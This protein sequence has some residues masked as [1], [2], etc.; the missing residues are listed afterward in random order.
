MKTTIPLLILLVAF[1]SCE[2]EQNDFRRGFLNYGLQLEDELTGINVVVRDSMNILIDEFY[3]I[4]Y[5]Q[6]NTGAI[7]RG[8]EFSNLLNYS[9]EEE[10]AIYILANAVCEKSYLEYLSMELAFGAVYH[11]LNYHASNYKEQFVLVEQSDRA[12][13]IGDIT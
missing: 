1:I 5:N 8:E 12:Y 6:S 13:F 9:T 10:K 4:A 2:K 7:L 11:C 3:Q